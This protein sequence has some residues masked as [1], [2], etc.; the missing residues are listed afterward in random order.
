[1]ENSFEQWKAKKKD[2]IDRSA[3]VIKNNN[4][5]N[6][7]LGEGCGGAVGEGEQG[8]ARDNFIHPCG[9]GEAAPGDSRAVSSDA[10]RQSRNRREGQLYT[11]SGCQG[12][13]G[14]EW[15]D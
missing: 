1:M 2:G 11:A 6:H 9:G 15:G 4:S 3:L 5:F 12:K 14:S 7:S 8:A 10:T 13:T